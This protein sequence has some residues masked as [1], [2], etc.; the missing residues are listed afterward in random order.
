M[1]A[2]NLDMD[3][4]WVNF[5]GVDGWLNDLINENTRPYEEAKPLV[6]LSLLART[7]NKLQKVGYEINIISWTS[8]EST[9]AFHEAVIKAKRAWLAKHIPSVRWNNIFIVPYGTPKQTLASGFLFDDEERNRTAW[10]EGARDEKDLISVL[11][12]LL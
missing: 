10:G 4:T 11:R 6:N 7:L 3:G 9:E 8:K 2:I 12:S 1:K 5:Y